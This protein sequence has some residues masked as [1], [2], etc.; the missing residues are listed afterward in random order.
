MCAKFVHLVFKK[1]DGTFKNRF[2]DPDFTRVRL[3]NDLRWASPP[4]L[5][6]FGLTPS[7]LS[8]LYLVCLGHLW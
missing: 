8:R 6:P 5:T 1:H 3:N 4:H 7:E 2:Y